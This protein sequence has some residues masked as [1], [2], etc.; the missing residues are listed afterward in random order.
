MMA[1]AV[2]A[3]R[4]RVESVDIVRVFMILMTLDHVCEFL[5]KSGL[6]LN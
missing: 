6:V 1:E 3:Q 2:P 5:G 4:V